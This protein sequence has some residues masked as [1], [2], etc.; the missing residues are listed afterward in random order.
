MGRL[1]PDRLPF[2]QTKPL[3]APGAHFGE[4][5]RME[6]AQALHLTERGGVIGLFSRARKERQGI[7]FRFTRRGAVHGQRLRMDAVEYL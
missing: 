4:R 1:D 3:G 6:P 7:I 2:S 5:L